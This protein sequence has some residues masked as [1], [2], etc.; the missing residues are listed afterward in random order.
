MRT[1]TLTLTVVTLLSTTATAQLNPMT[2][3]GQ[4]DGETWANYFGTGL[5]FGDF[6][7]DGREE[8]VAGAW[9]W[10]NQTGKN[11]FFQYENDWPDSP[12]MTVQGHQEFE[13]YDWYDANLGDINDDG[14][15]DLGIPEFGYGPLFEGRLD[16]YLGSAL[17]D[18]IP[19][20]TMSPD[21]AV[22]YYGGNLDSCEDINGDGW[23]DFL[24]RVEYYPSSAYRKL[25][26]YYGGQILDTIPDVVL[27]SENSTVKPVGDVNADGY[28]D[29]MVIQNQAPVRIY[30]GG[31]PMDTLADMVLYDESAFQEGAGLGDVNG[32][33]FPDFC[34][35][36]VFPD[37]TLPRDAV[38]WG[39]P[40]LDDQHDALLYTYWGGLNASLYGVGSGDFNGDG[41]NDIVS[42]TGD[43]VLGR[44]VYIYLG[45]LDFNGVP[46][47]LMTDY[48]V[49]NDFGSS[50]AS[51]DMNGDGRDELAITA[52]AYPT[53]S[54]D[55]RVYLYEGPPTWIDYGAGGVSPEEIGRY[56]EGFILRQN[57]PNPF[58]TSTTIHF[59]IA[60]PST[61]NMAIYDLHGRMVKTL[62]LGKTMLPGG[63]NVAWT[64]KDDAGRTVASGMYLLIMNVNNFRQMKKM[65]LIK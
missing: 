3:V 29:V 12:Y 61:V 26:I 11:Y 60:R 32:D 42:A 15:V 31:N 35:P 55:G 54:Y 30:F 44:V 8:M 1:I 53:G 22:T 47:A 18:T 17:F 24:M 7:G 13:G 36:M 43:M 10:N 48:S 49:L 57:Y 20:W 63:Y 16:V 65:V 28:S 4:Y 37:S 38:Y 9:G 52:G 6:D 14:F 45:S 59:E 23:N 2:L 27:N 33:D 58:N 46:D 34:L 40:N 51:G 41:I 5:T 19:D 50:L 64:G 25:E 62:I 56:P 21:S 39:G